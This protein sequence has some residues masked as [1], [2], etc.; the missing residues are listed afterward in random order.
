MGNCRH[1]LDFASWSV[2]PDFPLYGDEFSIS[3]NSAIFLYTAG[4]STFELALW[5]MLFTQG[6][7]RNKFLVFHWTLKW[8]IS[9]PTTSTQAGTRIPRMGV[10]TLNQSTSR[11]GITYQLICFLSLFQV[12]INLGAG[13]SEVSSPLGVR[14]DDLEWHEVRIVRKFADLKLTVDGVHKTR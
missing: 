2:W 5:Q 8:N 1:R 9:E 11:D 14:L 6:G 12:H 7:A 13:E 10:G 3:L 4:P